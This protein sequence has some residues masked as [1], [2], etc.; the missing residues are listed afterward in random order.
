MGNHGRTG[1]T[2]L[3][4]DLTAFQCSIV[5]TGGCTAPH[6]LDD[7]VQAQVYVSGGVKSAHN[8]A[9]QQCTNVVQGVRFALAMPAGVRAGMASSVR[10]VRPACTLAIVSIVPAR[11]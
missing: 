6:W 4:A 2:G 7:G 1:Q 8:L 9:A 3:Q 10:I 11:G 5:Q